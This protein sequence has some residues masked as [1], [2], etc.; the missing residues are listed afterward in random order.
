MGQ[1]SAAAEGDAALTS[2]QVTL[3][4][5]FMVTVGLISSWHWGTIHWTLEQQDI[6]NSGR[7]DFLLFDLPALRM[8]L[9]SL[10]MTAE[11]YVSSDARY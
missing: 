8:S 5:L 1:P 6:D 10:G 11:L 4:I 9:F 7:T 3:P 2:Y